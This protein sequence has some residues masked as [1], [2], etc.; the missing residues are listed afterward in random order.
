MLCRRYTGLEVTHSS[1]P[2]RWPHYLLYWSLRFLKYG[3]NT[4]QI[5]FLLHQ[6]KVSTKHKRIFFEVTCF[7]FWAF[8]ILLRFSGLISM[9]S[10]NLF[11]PRSISIK[12]LPSI[13]CLPFHTIAGIS[14]S[15]V[16]VK[17]CSISY[18]ATTSLSRSSHTCC[19][20]IWSQKSVLFAFSALQH[21][22][23]TSSFRFLVLSSSSPLLP[24]YVIHRC[25]V[26]Q[27]FVEKFAKFQ[28]LDTWKH[29]QC[30]WIYVICIQF[31]ARFLASSF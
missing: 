12:R 5:E 19:W 29:W 11:P 27:V 8:L 23:F 16:N 9:A 17:S 18:L 15:Y 6:Q 25:S 14:N 13:F 26:T 30:Y 2:P 31:T 20:S 24:F 28:W 10:V 3:G 7:N 22:C 1:V 4:N 21:F